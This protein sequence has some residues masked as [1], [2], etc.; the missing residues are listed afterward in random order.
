MKLLML[1]MWM[2]LMAKN[3][4]ER[5]LYGVLVLRIDT[6][7]TLLESKVLIMENESKLANCEPI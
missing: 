2:D 4:D 1:S 6:F 5:G 7:P 3:I